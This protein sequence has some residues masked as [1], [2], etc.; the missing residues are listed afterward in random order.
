MP[1]IKKEKREYLDNQLSMLTG[2]LRGEPGELSYVLT[3]ICLS[4]LQGFPGKYEDFA[5]IVGVLDLTKAEF[6]RR[7]VEPYEDEKIKSNGDVF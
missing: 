4:M 1:Y 6:V 2:A 7:M 5:S 3:R